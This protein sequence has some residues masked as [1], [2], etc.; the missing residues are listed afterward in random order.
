MTHSNRKERETVS[1]RQPQKSRG[2]EK[3]INGILHNCS[4]TARFRTSN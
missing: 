3:T 4:M 2:E 1:K